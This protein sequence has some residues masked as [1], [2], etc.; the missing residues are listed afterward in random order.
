MGKI[1]LTWVLD[2]ASEFFLLSSCNTVSSI[3]I[4]NISQLT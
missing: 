2:K 3:Y 1:G 4:D